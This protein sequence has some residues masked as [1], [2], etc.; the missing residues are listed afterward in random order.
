[1]KIKLPSV[2]VALVLFCAL[3]PFRFGEAAGTGVYCG[4]APNRTDAMDFPSKH[5]WN[6]FMSLIQ[7]AKD[8]KTARGQPDCAKKIGTPGT[9]SVWET[10]RLARTEVFLAD[11]SEPPAWE[12]T[13]LPRGYLGTVPDATPSPHA[14]F[15]RLTTLFDPET[16]NGVFAGRGGIGETHMNRATY[17]FIKKN[18]LYS[19]TGLNR[20]AA[21]VAE[22]KKQALSFPTDSVEV[23][24]VWIEFTSEDIAKKRH[25]RHYIATVTGKTYGLVSFHV[26]TK[27]TPNWFW[28][29]FHHVD[30][31]KG[32]FETPDT[33]VRPS[34]LDGTVWANYVLGGTQVDFITPTG[35]PTIVSDHY[36][37]FGFEK[38]SCM[39]CHANANGSPDGSKGPAQT[40]GIG[41]PLPETFLKNGKPFFMQTDFVWSIP[42]RAKPSTKPLPTSCS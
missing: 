27:D 9:T 7:P 15:K 13:S 28:A 6:L 10:W 14:N 21:S 22:G 31:P 16:N 29:T 26:L 35:A 33:Y 3:I 39:T 5:A 17:D 20:Y 4:N 12:D 32:Q 24:A 25:L 38:S 18:C 1:M 34:V 19:T 11:G 2:F 40:L 23:K 42:F 37:E 30:N 8:I 41:I 36:I